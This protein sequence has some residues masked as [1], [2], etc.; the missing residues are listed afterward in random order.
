MDGWKRFTLSSGIE[1]EYGPFPNNLYWD[2][3]A[4]AL[5]EHP[6]PVPTKKRVETFDGDEEVDDLEDPEF[7]TKLAAARLARFN[8]LGEAALEFCVEIVAPEDWEKTLQRLAKKYVRDP[9]PE[10]QVDR[11]V[12]YL[13]HFAM[14]TPQDWNLIRKIQS[15]SQIEDEE[16][17]QRA[18]FFRRDVAGPEG[19]GADAPG[20]AA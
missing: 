5:G 2:I 19:D 13:A 18:E 4:R 12:W 16:V 10:D 3:Q 1:V 20:A 9:L 17:R 7:K 11:K 8:L 6:D 14:R 15:F